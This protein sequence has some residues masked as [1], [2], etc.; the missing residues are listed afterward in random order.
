MIFES[1]RDRI[2]VALDVP[3]ADEARALVERLGDEATS[4]K[5]GLQLFCAAGPEIVSEFAKA[6]KRI[7]LD[8]KFHDI[9]NTVAGAVRSVAGLG[10]AVMNVHCSGGMEM[11]RTAAETAGGGILVI[12]VTVL[13]SLN[14]DDLKE[15]GVAHTTEGQVLQFAR[16]ANEAGL[17]GV[18]C[19]A[20]EIG[21]LRRE[22]G[23][24]FLLITPGI[25]P[26]WAASG[27]QKRI[28]TPSEAFKKGASALVIGRPITGQD[29]P[30]AAMRRILD[31][32]A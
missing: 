14:D 2:F 23:D 12:G 5:I 20:K 13:T 25:R 24:D 22:I 32:C 15:M 29:N 4:Y 19:S 10:A 16:M 1:I 6:G 31:E 27:D 28:V 26:E 7:F 3:T 21:M 8:L 30:A 17:D 9:P 18:V 11:M